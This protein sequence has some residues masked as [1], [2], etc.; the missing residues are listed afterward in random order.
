MI[1]Q[2]PTSFSA[3]S[4]AVKL[5]RHLDSKFKRRRQKFNYAND[6]LT[7]Q[8]IQL[9]FGGFLYAEWM[10]WVLRNSIIGKSL[11]KLR[12]CFETGVGITS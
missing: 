6:C 10:L 7:I 4:Y 8:K 5:K 9:Q 2:K 3:K 12:M 11:T 1:V